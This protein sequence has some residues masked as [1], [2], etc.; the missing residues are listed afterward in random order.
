MQYTIEIMNLGNW[1]FCPKKSSIR[2]ILRPQVERESCRCKQFREFA[3]KKRVFTD[4]YEK[5]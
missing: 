3:R 4:F 1:K 5:S 2:S